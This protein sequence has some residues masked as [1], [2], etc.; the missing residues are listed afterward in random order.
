MRERAECG[1]KPGQKTGAD[2]GH[3]DGHEFLVG[4]DLLAVFRRKDARGQDLVRVDQDGEGQGGGQQGKDI[5]K[6]DSRDRQPRQPGRHRADDGHALG[7]QVEHGRG[8]NG[9]DDDDE[10]A[11]QRTIHAA[12]DEQRRHADDADGDGEQ[13]RFVE[14]ADEFHNLPEELVALELDAEHLAQ[15]AADDDQRRAKDVADQDRL[16]QKVGDEPQPRHA[17]E[18]RQDAD[19]DRGQRRQCGV[20]RRVAA[21]PAAQR[22][23]RS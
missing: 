13:V 3:A 7:L 12:H 2:I 18:Q 9:Q 8:D 23:R 15:L 17:G 10:R 4:I 20:A 1:R 6:A 5:L 21:R 11:G 19:Q 22:R 14:A 16:G